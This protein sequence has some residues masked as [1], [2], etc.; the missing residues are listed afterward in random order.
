MDISRCSILIS[1]NDISLNKPDTEGGLIM[2]WVC[3]GKI[4][5]E[6]IGVWKTVVDG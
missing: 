6:G 4:C 2:N 5:T 3:S 1:T